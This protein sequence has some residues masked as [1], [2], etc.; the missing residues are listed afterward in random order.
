MP[1][2]QPKIL[3]TGG[4]GFLGSQI[5]KLLLENKYKVILLVRP[6]SN[7]RKIKDF[8]SD[9]NLKIVRS[10]KGLRPVF[11]KKI[12]FIIHTATCYGRDDELASE[13]VD[14][15]LSLPLELLELG[16]RNGLRAFIN[17]DTFFN[18]QIYLKPKER[19]Y[20]K[21]KKYFIGIADDIL[22]G[23]ATKFVNLKIQQMYGPGDSVKKFVPFIISELL[24][25][26]KKIPLTKGEQRRDFIYVEDVALAFLKAIEKIDK[27]GLK[28]EFGIGTGRSM[29]IRNFVL[30][31]KK[32][33]ASRGLLK[34]GAIPY[35]KN[36][37]K[38][39]HANIRRNKKISWK[40]E[41]RVAEGIRNTAEYFKEII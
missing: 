19:V 37:I 6:H 1:D 28:E 33:C 24:S 10:R 14:A 31:A 32:V 23:S 25:G 26:R 35:R 16:V 9:G 38:N 3:L 17:A 21:T 8:V 20:V 22:G 5:L 27:L 39:S 29:S 11:A 36:E 13:I 2:K 4:T 12:D 15:N 30:Q 40:A 41:T 34:W 7:F 18:E